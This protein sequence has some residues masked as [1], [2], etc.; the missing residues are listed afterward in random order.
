MLNK[1]K[2]VYASDVFKLSALVQLNL[3]VFKI[4]QAHANFGEHLIKKIAD[5]SFF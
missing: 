3:K 4:K 2:M 5:K 1:R